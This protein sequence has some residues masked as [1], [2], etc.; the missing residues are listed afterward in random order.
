M[1]LFGTL[2]KWHENYS[3][4][5]TLYVIEPTEFFLV[6]QHNSRLINEFEENSDW[7]R[8]GYHGNKI[9]F[10]EDTFYASG[11]YLF[12]HAR[13]K[14]RAGGTE[15]LRLHYW[16]ATEV[17]KQFLYNQGVRTLLYPDDDCICYKDDYF[18]HCGL[19]HY[20]TRVCYEKMSEINNLTLFIGKPFIAAFTHEWCF[21]KVADKI[22]ISLEHYHKNNYEF[23]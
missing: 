8:F 16:Y 1:R 13:Q 11:F 7:L 9:H 23:V 18:K 10:N 15:I 3:I 14:L 17:Q 19:Y 2:K 5:C 6:T 12:E 4:K 21:D 20:R 22:R